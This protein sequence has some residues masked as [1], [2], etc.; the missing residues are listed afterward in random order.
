VVQH[1]KTYGSQYKYQKRNG[2][3]GVGLSR[4]YRWRPPVRPGFAKA[5]ELPYWH[6]LGLIILAFF[7]GRA[8]LLGELSPFVVAFAGAVLYLYG[9]WGW[10]AAGAGLAG[11]ATVLSPAEIGPEFLVLLAVGLGLRTIPSDFRRPQVAVAVLAGTATIVIKGSYL[12]FSGAALYDF[13]AVFFESSLA[14]VLA[15]VFLVALS[16]RARPVAVEEFCCALVLLAAS[17]AGTGNLEYGLVS[18]HGLV[19]KFII[20]VAA[21]LG[22]VGLGAAGGAVV[23]ILPG[24]AYTVT[25]AVIG[26]YAFAGF[27]GGF[28]RRF[29]KPGVAAGFILGNI[30]LA[31][32]I[33]EYRELAGVL[34]EVGVAAALFAVLPRRWFEALRSLIP[35]GVL[36]SGE[37]KERVQELVRSRVR[38]WARMFSELSRTFAQVSPAGLDVGSEKPLREL[39]N[40]VKGRICQDCNLY[41]G[42]WERDPERA[43]REFL[44]TLARVEATGRVVPEDFPG[45]IRR[46]CLRLKE[47]AVAL[48][49]L[50][51]TYQ[52]NRYWYRRLVE[53]REMVSENLR[54]LSQIMHNL[55]TE[56]CNSI[57]RASQVDALLRRK[58]RELDVPVHRIEAR[59]REDDRLEVTVSRPTCHGELACHYVVA[60]V[61]SRALGQPF[62]VADTSCAREEDA[63]ECSFRLRPALRYRVAV[64]L[65]QMG[66][67]GSAVSGDTASYL[68]LA[69]GRF[70]LLLS[71]GMGVGSQAA[72]ESSTTVS[73]LE[74]MFQAGFGKDMAVKTVNS[75][76][77]LRAPDE[78]FATVDLAVVDLHTGE[79]EFVKIGAAPS[80][81][82]GADTVSVVEGDALPVGI[83]REINFS[84]VVR[85][86]AA[87][88]LVVMVTDGVT[89]SYRGPLEKETWLGE[90]LRDL[91]RTDP[92]QVAD[93]VLQQARRAAGGS[94]PDDMTVLVGRIENTDS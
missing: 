19:S 30:T 14:G 84:V 89:D 47:M 44:D 91:P 40:E 21:F 55:A 81:I 52:V 83:I 1:A 25:P 80:F 59:H 42:C 66:K 15:Y 71:D 60:P 78:S 34:A 3:A 12:A 87:G 65:A 53:S 93:L 77:L 31:V 8:V 90:L 18:L 73:L 68:E 20:L 62:T 94:V 51:E 22:G 88:D 58:L 67:N 6:K 41:R 70:A 38:S 79:V 72:L 9:P 43:N 48:T 7:L 57:E 2:W 37:A 75:I 28:F 24:I 64:G 13:V 54:G 27:L 32:Y 82:V 56:L 33:G 45:D 5:L 17:L 46:K 10:L 63:A 29:G 50:Y 85:K 69:D 76:L 26:V 92:Q 61:V 23:G 11:Q 35:A 74:H 4:R 16:P 36:G 86:L 49:C 39:L